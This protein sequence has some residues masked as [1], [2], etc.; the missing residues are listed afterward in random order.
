V[1]PRTSNPGATAVSSISDTSCQRHGYTASLVQAPLFHFLA[2]H[3]GAQS[4]G[5]P[6]VPSRRVRPRH[7]P[8]ALGDR[9]LESPPDTP[10]VGDLPPLTRTTWGL[11]L[12]SQSQARHASRPMRTLAYRLMITS[13]PDAY[14]NDCPAVPNAANRTANR[15]PP[16]PGRPPGHRFRPGVTPSPTAGEPACLA[17]ARIRTVGLIPLHRIEDGRP[18]PRWAARFDSGCRAHGLRPWRPKP[19]ARRCRV[20]RRW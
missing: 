20:W 6:A 18:V 13:E 7:S 9:E 16:P 15:T 2:E 17:R 1:P 3:G 10:W 19:G 5:F 12:R 4:T 14:L 8:A 11:S